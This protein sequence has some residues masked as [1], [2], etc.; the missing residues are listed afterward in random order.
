MLTRSLVKLNHKKI[1][2]VRCLTRNHWLKIFIRIPSKDYS[3]EDVSHSQLNYSG[4]NVLLFHC[5]VEHSV[6]P[7]SHFLQMDSGST[8]ILLGNWQYCCISDILNNSRLRTWNLFKKWTVFLAIARA[9]DTLIINVCIASAQ[10]TQ[11]F[12]E[13]IQGYKIQDTNNRYKESI[14]VR[15]TKVTCHLSLTSF[16]TKAWCRLCK[17]IDHRLPAWKSFYLLTIYCCYQALLLD[18][19]ISV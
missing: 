9:S 19:K 15:S 7:G 1:D 5:Y 13:Q 14:R 18:E 11:L 17:I 12:T 3:A 8:V 4:S 16:M 10:K 2:V 6:K